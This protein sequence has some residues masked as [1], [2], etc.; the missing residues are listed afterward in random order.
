MSLVLLFSNHPVVI[1]YGQE[2]YT[3]GVQPAFFLLSLSTTTA[4]YPQEHHLQI[5]KF[6]SFAN[7]DALFMNDSFLNHHKSFCANNRSFT[8]GRFQYSSGFF[9]FIYFF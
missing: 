8:E 6:I 7:L 1:F 9:L 3:S 2:Y 4:N 5:S